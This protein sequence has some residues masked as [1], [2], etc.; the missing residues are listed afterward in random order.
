MSRITEIRTI[1]TPRGVVAIRAT[2]A[3]DASRLRALRLEALTVSPTSFGS[4]VEEIDGQDWVVLARGGSGDACFVAQHA[5]VLIG[6]AGIHRSSRRKAGH[7][8]DLWGVYVQPA[9]RRHGIAGAMVTACVEWAARAGVAIVKLTAV[10]ESGALGCYLR[11]GFRV[12]GVDPAAL[13]WD[14]RYYDEL[15]MC[16]WISQEPPH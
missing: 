4:A 2:M 1:K 13:R 11:C 7:H 16:R 15:M 8:A 9:W 14:G 10:P 6:L 3:E 12:T 5:G